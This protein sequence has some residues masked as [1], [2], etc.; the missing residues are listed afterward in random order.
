MGNL[1][2]ICIMDTTSSQTATSTA[3]DASND[4]DGST[5]LRA[6]SSYIFYDQMDTANQKMM[7]TFISQGSSG[8]IEA[9]TK[10]MK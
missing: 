5:L 2:N 6:D 4:V 7:N 10:E 9:I 8:F 1:F 3:S